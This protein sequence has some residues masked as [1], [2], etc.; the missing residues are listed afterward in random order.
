VYASLKGI[1]QPYLALVLRTR[2]F[3]LYPLILTLS[4]RATF[5]FRYALAYG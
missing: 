3:M 4:T 5:G 2:C 1:L